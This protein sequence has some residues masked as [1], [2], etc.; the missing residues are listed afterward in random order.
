MRRLA[1]LGLALI[2]AAA[3]C[4]AAYIVLAQRATRVFSGSTGLALAAAVAWL[5]PLG[6][7]LA[8]GG[9]ELLAPATL[10][11]GAAV[12][13]L[14]SVIPYTLETESLRRM[15]AN[16]FGVLMSLEPAVAAV[17]GFLVLHQHLGTRDVLAI[18]LVIA[19]SIGVTRSRPPAPEA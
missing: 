18:G 13:L 14:S 2:L 6:P 5:M 3:T 7:G 4:W 12:A 8:E 17:A 15:P 19:A 10:A 1:L 11:V 16:V 9:A